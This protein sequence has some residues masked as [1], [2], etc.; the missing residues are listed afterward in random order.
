MNV[1]NHHT[2]IHIN[3]ALKT[4]FCFQLK[5]LNFGLQVT[6]VLKCSKTS[7]NA[8][9]SDSLDKML[10]FIRFPKRVGNITVAVDPLVCPNH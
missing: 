8:E 3:I 10:A 6:H 2:C 1:V 4:L 5:I 7:D 9:L